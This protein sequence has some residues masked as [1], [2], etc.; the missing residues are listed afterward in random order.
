MLR[1]LIKDLRTNGIFWGAALVAQVLFVTTLVVATN[2]FAQ[3]DLLLLG[4]AEALAN[5]IAVVSLVQSDGPS[6]R[7]GDW[8]VRPV[9][10]MSVL[11]AKMATVGAIIL[12]P[13]MLIGTAMAGL[14]H[15]TILEAATATGLRLIADLMILALAFALASATRDAAEAATAAGMFLATWLLV[16]MRL[17]RLHIPKG[18]LNLGLPALTI[19]AATMAIALYRGSKSM[20][21]RWGL[22][23]A[24]LVW[25]P[26]TIGALIAIEK[27][28]PPLERGETAATRQ[29]SLRVAEFD[30]YGPAQG[31]GYGRYLKSIQARPDDVRLR[32]TKIRVFK[33]SGSIKTQIQEYGFHSGNISP[34]T[35]YEINLDN[36]ITRIGP[37]DRMW[38]ELDY[39]VYRRKLLR[40]LPAQDGVMQRVEGIGSCMLKSESAF[41]ASVA[42]LS[43]VKPK[44]L[45]EFEVRCSNQNQTEDWFRWP[46][47]YASDMLFLDPLNAAAP[48]STWK[49]EGQITR[50]ITLTR[51]ELDAL[52]RPLSAEQIARF[53][54][55]F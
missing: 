39:T 26:V 25:A 9:G 53:I 37:K 30:R 7:L 46:S 31:D 55:R 43:A 27:T 33:I 10:W 48:L 18:D 16:I 4:L 32:R 6:N 19:V 1:I 12:L 44:C 54:T 28:R 42:C 45:S 50:H 23:V 24:G 20:T 52:A 47:P 34:D 22:A 49:I 40:P 5:T 41:S 36:S 51:R 21:L 3:S 35:A 14:F 15:Q 38:I 8:R 2:P 17:D 29:V 13:H 11:L